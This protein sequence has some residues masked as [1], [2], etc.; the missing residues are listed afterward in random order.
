MMQERQIAE[1]DTQSDTGQRKPRVALMGEFSAGKSTLSNFLLGGDPFPV[2]ITA[3]RLP[4]IWSS[5]GEKSAVAVDHDGYERQVDLRNLSSATLEDT[6]LIRV[7]RKADLLELCD[8]VDMPG[9]SDPNMPAHVWLSILKEIDLVVWCTHATQAWRQT[10]A[11]I[12]EQVMDGTT[13]RNILLITQADKLQSARDRRKV[14]N[15]VRHE[16]DGQFDAVFAVSVQQA[17]EA[18][19]DTEALQDS[20]ILDFLDH[21]VETLVQPVDSKVKKAVEWETVPELP[22]WQSEERRRAAADR[23]AAH[24]GAPKDDM[25]DNAQNKPARLE[26]VAEEKV[27]P[28]R[29]ERVGRSRMRPVRSE[30][31]NETL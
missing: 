11:A 30:T 31:V 9:T 16:T 15:R 22:E 27:V 4:P 8:W 18:A 21:L 10:E 14:I 13:G 20:G 25:Q 29:V 19:D 26:D 23:P 2:R 24:A 3:T 17:A 1:T 6:A 7:K 5:Y 12:W 28:K